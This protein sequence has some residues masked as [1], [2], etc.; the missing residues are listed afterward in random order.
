LLKLQDEAH[1]T[2]MQRRLRKRHGDRD[3]VSRITRYDVSSFLDW[4]VIA[5][6]K[7]AGAYFADKIISPGTPSNWPG[8]LSR[9]SSRMLILRLVRPNLSSIRPCSPSSSMHSMP[10]S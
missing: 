6:A 10:Q 7:K 4:G 5:D 9:F 8:W 1:R 2:D 3:F